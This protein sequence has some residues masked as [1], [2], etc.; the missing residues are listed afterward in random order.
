[1]GNHLLDNDM[2]EEDYKAISEDD[3]TRRPNN[4]PALA[5]VECNPQILGALKTDAKRAD[6]LLRE[7]SADIIKAGTI[8]IKLLLALDRVVQ[9]DSHPVVTQ[10]VGMINGAVVVLGRANHRANLA[11][12]F[13]MKREINQKYAHL[14][15]VM[16][17]MS[18]FLFGEDVSQSAKQIDETEKMKNKFSA[19]KSTSPWKF[20]SGRSTGFWGR[21]VQRN[22]SARF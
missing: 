14:C 5:P 1:M 17:P 12:R 21:A 3:I 18:R 8:I 22:S 16:V 2:Q 6:S 19:T 7:V 10:E 13:I 15:N 20:K 4:C 11:R 9:G